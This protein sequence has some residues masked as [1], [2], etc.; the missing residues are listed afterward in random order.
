MTRT[1][2][3]LKV[4]LLLVIACTSFSACSDDDDDDYIYNRLDTTTV[5]RNLA[6]D[7]VDHHS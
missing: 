3:F 7:I 2:D 4:L 1:K 5:R 6:T